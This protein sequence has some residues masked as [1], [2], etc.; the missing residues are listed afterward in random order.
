MIGPYSAGCNQPERV[1]FALE[2]AAIA[3][4]VPQTSQLSR[5]RF[6]AE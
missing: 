6:A 4:I 1:I 2:S 5:A 3:G